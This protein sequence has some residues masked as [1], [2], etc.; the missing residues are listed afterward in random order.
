MAIAK[1]QPFPEF[2]LE[3]KMSLWEERRDEG[4]KLRRAIPKRAG[5]L[6]HRRSCNARASRYSARP[7]L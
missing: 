3:R 6:Y 5:N 2:D 1:F 4:K 7:F